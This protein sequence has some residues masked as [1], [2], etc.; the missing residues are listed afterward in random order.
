MSAIFTLAG[1]VWMNTVRRKDIYVLLILLMVALVALVSL[2]VFGLGSTSAYIKDVGLLLTW[3]FGWLISVIASTRE[4]PG[5]EQRR[6]VFTILS[7][8][9]SRGQYVTGKWLGTWLVSSVAVSIFYLLVIGVT[10]LK[11][12]SIVTC[13]LMQALYMHI[14]LLGVIC[15]LGLAFSTRM[16]H[17]AAATMTFVVTTVAFLV[18]PRVPQFMVKETGFKADL[19]MFVYNLFPHFEVFDLRRRVVHGYD[20]IGAGPILSITAY[21]LALISLF[22]L[23]AWLAY[24]KKTFARDRIGS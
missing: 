24:R 12:G 8:P 1:I 7:K 21:G 16:N 23:I 22:I 3:F 5:E 9:V 13:T 14:L 15:A 20:P 6:T 4:I 10:A 17:D 11:G 19:L 18:V 2:D